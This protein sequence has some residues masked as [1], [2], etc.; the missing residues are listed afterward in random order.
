M[1]THNRDEFAQYRLYGELI[2]QKKYELLY[3]KSQ[4]FELPIAKKAVLRTYERKRLIGELDGNRTP[5]FWLHSF[6][7]GFLWCYRTRSNAYSLNH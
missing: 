6:L 4:H 7:S 1:A 3:V 2:A 5:R